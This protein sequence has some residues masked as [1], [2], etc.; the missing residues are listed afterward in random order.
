MSRYLYRKEVEVVKKPIVEP[1]SDSEDENYTEEEL[2]QVEEVPIEEEMKL[3]DQILENET[4]P[5]DME[6]I[7]KKQQTLKRKRGEKVE[8]Q[9][10][11]SQ[12]AKQK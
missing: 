8:K 7:T 5:F 6:Q 2:E 12:E 4:K 11:I 1:V 3:L 9:R 10:V